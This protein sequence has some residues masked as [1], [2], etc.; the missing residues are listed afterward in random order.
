MR[1]TLKEWRYIQYDRQPAAENMALDQYLIK[2]YKK[3]GRPVFRIYGWNPA[4]IS[5]GKNQ[6]VM[7]DINIE[8]CTEDEMC[9]VRRITGGGAIF[10]SNE[11]TYSLVCSEADI[12]CKNLGVK[13]SFEKL[14]AFLI[15]FYKTIGVKAAFAKDTLKKAKFGAP[16]AFCFAGTEEYDIAAGGKK[17]GGNAQA[18]GK[19]IIF[20]HGSIP[21]EKE[22]EKAQRYFNGLINHDA[23][24]CLESLLKKRPEAESLEKELKKAFEKAL[25]IKLKEEKLLEKEKEAVDTLTLGKY[26]S[27]EWNLKGGKDEDA[28]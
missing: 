2:Y 11:L 5:V 23:F 10:H 20:Q 26:S 8:N 4:A 27:D 12:N 28:F 9:I 19:D 24:T 17:I 22:S 7:R 6:D 3:T 25:G 13:E 15:E 18:R 1:T 21:I 16:S 14:N